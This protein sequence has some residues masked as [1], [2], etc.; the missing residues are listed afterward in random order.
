MLL[1][2]IMLVFLAGLFL[3]GLLL[4][5]LLLVELLLVELFM[6]C[7]PKKMLDL[8]FPTQVCSVVRSW[9]FAVFPVVYWENGVLSLSDLAVGAKLSAW[10][11]VADL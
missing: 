8:T 2:E 4:V 7:S 9:I 11:E 10:L 6:V 1:P 3:A 5:E